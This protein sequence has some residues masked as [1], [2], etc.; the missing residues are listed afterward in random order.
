MCFNLK[1]IS[2]EL[3]AER[4]GRRKESQSVSALGSDGMEP[5]APPALR[6]TLTWSSA[7][8]WGKTG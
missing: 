3:S 7:V 4:R 5:L 8:D 1:K 2:A 6:E